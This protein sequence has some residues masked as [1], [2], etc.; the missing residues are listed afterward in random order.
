MPV[1]AAAARK[2]GA[3]CI[4]A[5]CPLCQANLEQRP[6]EAGLPVFYITQLLGLA[7]GLDY[8]KLGI[9]RHIIDCRPLLREH[10]LI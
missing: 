1:L 9:D 7:M 8:K 10:G 4:V 3:N 6:G 2:A 5:A